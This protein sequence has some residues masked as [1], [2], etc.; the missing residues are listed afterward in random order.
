M[1]GATY[2][3]WLTDDYG[4]RITNQRGETVIDNVLWGTFTRVV[5]EI[6][7]IRLAL[8]PS[9]DTSIIRIDNMLQVWRAPQG[10]RL[11][12]WRAYFIRKWR[13]ETTGSAEHLLV[14]GRDAND[15]LRRRIVAAYAGELQSSKDDY[16]DDMMKEVVTESLA[17]GVAPTPD[18]GT[19]VW[20]D[21]SIAPDLGDGP[22]ITKAFAF[23]P[24]L[25]KSGGGALAQIADAAREAGTEVFF[26]VVP[27]MISPTAITFEFRTYT[28]QPGQDVSGSVVFDQ[29]RGNLKDP[30]LEYD[31]TDEA[32]YVYACGGAQETDRVIVQ[33]YRAGRYNLSQWN[34]CEASIQAQSQGTDTLMIRE[35][36]RS[37]LADGRPVWRVG[38]KPLDT[39]ITRFG[40]DWNW[41]YKVRQRY[42]KTEFDAIVRSVVIDISSTG[43]ETIQARMD[44][45]SN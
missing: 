19:R 11:G 36:G 37:R 13:W 43:E 21:L 32:N 26:D 16:A 10:G 44:N 14:T 28:G 15:L 34:R 2:E 45:E 17:D 35:A 24:L 40:I 5:N 41:G 22:A 12:L 18:A 7:S 6:G 27:K 3:F 39:Q 38:G 9:F 23:D 25:T 4:K 31:A 8:P 42:R 29:D 30:Y 20:A 33:V 1:P